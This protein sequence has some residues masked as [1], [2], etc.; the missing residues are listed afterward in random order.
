MC[1]TPSGISSLL[2]DL[3]LEQPFPGPGAE[4]LHSS[5]LCLP[6][7]LLE[8]EVSRLRHTRNL[9]TGR[10]E[11]TLFQLKNTAAQWVRRKQCDDDRLDT[12]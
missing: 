8:G 5:L 7:E 12:T 11:V 2:R 1:G 4:S 10:R 9:R 3:R 6:G